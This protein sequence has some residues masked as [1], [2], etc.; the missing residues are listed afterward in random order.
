MVQ[1]VTFRLH[2]AVP[3]PLIEHWKREL[4][5]I[6][7][8]SDNDTE[9]FAAQRREMHRRL[10]IYEDA[11]YGGCCLRMDSVAQVIAGALRHFDGQRYA[12]SAWCI[13][14]NHV[15]TL[16][17]VLPGWRTGEIVHSW[18]RHTA[19]K[20]NAILGTNGSFWAPDYYDRY[21]RDDAH[22]RRAIAYI[23]ANPVKAGLCASEEQWAWSSAT[24]NVQPDNPERSADF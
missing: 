18:K 8:R 7:K 5:W 4:Q 12:L 13:M 10:A 16:F 22:Y 21:I 9:A 14:P 2:D 6:E 17:R 1:G 3:Q 20:A 11:G 23:H 15:H 24:Q 19:R